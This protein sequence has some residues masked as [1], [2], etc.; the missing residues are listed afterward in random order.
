MTHVLQLH[1]LRC[2]GWAQVD[3]KIRRANKISHNTIELKLY[4]V[5]KQ[6]CNVKHFRA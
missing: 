4:S 2:L 1:S 5:S 3:F 6:S